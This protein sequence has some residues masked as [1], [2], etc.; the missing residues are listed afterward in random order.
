M[1]TPSQFLLCEYLPMPRPKLHRVVCDCLDCATAPTV[2]AVCVAARQEPPP[3]CL[4]IYTDHECPLGENETAATSISGYKN[5]PHLDGL[6]KAGSCGLIFYREAPQGKP[7]RLKR[8]P[9]LQIRRQSLRDGSGG[10]LSSISQLLHQVCVF[11]MTWT[12][13]VINL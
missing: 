10:N 11:A 3:K 12:S 7:S 2:S 1:L 8:L 4:L 9:S 5:V 13:Q 6:A